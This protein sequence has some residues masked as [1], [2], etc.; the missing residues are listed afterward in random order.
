MK[1]IFTAPVIAELEIGA[2][3]DVMAAS[4]LA[5]KKDNVAYGAA[6]FADD[7]A[8]F[9]GIWHGAGEGWL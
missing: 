3:E 2:V 1:K 9:G 6:D 5:V 7:S 8:D 4:M